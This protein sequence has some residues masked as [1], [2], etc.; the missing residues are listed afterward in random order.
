MTTKAAVVF[1]YKSFEHI[2]RD[3]GTQSWRMH[4]SHIGS[5]GYVVCA[6]N[7]RHNP[8]EGPEEHGSAFLLG[9]VKDVVP[10]TDPEAIADAKKTGKKRYLIRMNEA[11]IINIPK[12]W[13]WGRWPTHYDDL[14]ALKIDPADYEFKPLADMLAE[15]LIATEVSKPVRTPVSPPVRGLREY[16]EAA[17]VSL[18]AQLGIDASAIEITVR[19]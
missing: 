13:Q 8:V 12:F 9:K 19:I 14:Q 5:F 18:G 4:S 16:I 10:T 1:T 7:R 2:L 11:A 15:M 3:G 6:R 17:K